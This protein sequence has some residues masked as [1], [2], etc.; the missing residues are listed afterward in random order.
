MPSSKCSNYKQKLWKCIFKLFFKKPTVKLLAHTHSHILAH[1]RV[2][3]LAF[4][5]LLVRVV[6]GG[7]G[8]FGNSRRTNTTS[9]FSLLFSFVCSQCNFQHF[10]HLLHLPLAFLLCFAYWFALFWLTKRRFLLA[11]RRG[12]WR[13]HLHTQTHIDTQTRSSTCICDN[14]ERNK[15]STVEIKICLRF[16][17]HTSARPRRRTPSERAESHREAPRSNPARSLSLPLSFCRSSGCAGEA[18]RERNEIFKVRSQWTKPN[19]ASLLLLQ[20]LLSGGFFVVAF[21]LC[22]CW[23]CD[24]HL[25]WPKWQQPQQLYSFWPVTCCSCALFELT[26]AISELCLVHHC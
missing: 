6:I 13:S 20:L 21:W 7:I 8:V 4:V 18:L 3:V 22:F 11:L 1:T 19:V 10:T 14:R 16:S 25:P 2:S 17:A 24:S 23:A 26:V 15:K 9:L 5:W 12:H